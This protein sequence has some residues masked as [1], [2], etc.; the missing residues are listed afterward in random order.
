MCVR[1]GLCG[2]VCV[3]GVVRV[4]VC[5][6]GCAG[7]CV[8]ERCVW[9]CM[10]VREGYGNECELVGTCRTTNRFEVAGGIGNK[11]EAQD[12]ERV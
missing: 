4:G 10:C 1:E 6:R 2:W 12:W 3:G 7:V 5:G 8:R 11:F 9:V